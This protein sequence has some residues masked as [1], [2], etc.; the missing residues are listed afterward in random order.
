MSTLHIRNCIRMI[1]RYNAARIWNMH[2][3]ASMLQGEMAVD[4]AESD[5]AHVEAYGF[6]DW[7]EDYIYA[8]EQELERRGYEPGKEK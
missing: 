4:A 8:F 5:I 6:E 1:E 2:L 3:L 7:A